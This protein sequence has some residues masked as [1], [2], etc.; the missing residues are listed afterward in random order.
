MLFE[1]N[2]LLRTYRQ[3]TSSP[4]IA[5]AEFVVN[6]WDAE[7]STVDIDI[8]VDKQKKKGLNKCLIEI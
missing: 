7:A 8:A 3:L 4:D 1:D 5:L 6:A 2:Y